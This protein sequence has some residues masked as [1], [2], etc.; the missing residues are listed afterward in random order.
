[1]PVGGPCN[2]IRD[3]NS[4][5]AIPERILNVRS[6]SLHFPRSSTG[7]TPSLV[8]RRRVWANGCSLATQQMQRLSSLATVFHCS[9]DSPGRNAFDAYRMS[10]MTRARVRNTQSFRPLGATTTRRVQ[11]P[12]LKSKEWP[13]KGS[14]AK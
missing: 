9:A 8:Y 14:M 3:D 12:L 11:S 6:W 4:S 10:C 1:M 13:E 7:Q 5:L 2:T